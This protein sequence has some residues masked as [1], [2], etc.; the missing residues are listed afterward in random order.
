MVHFI[1][2]RMGCAIELKIQ[3]PSDVKASKQQFYFSSPLKENNNIG[4]LDGNHSK[5]ADQ[6]YQLWKETVFEMLVEI[7]V[8]GVINT[9]LVNVYLFYNLKLWYVKSNWMKMKDKRNNM[10]GCQSFYLWLKIPHLL[11]SVFKLQYLRQ[12]ASNRLKR[13]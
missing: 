13:T 3:W 4:T 1:N 11:S 6:T 2:R 9:I 7:I 5:M 10:Q 8:L 12:C